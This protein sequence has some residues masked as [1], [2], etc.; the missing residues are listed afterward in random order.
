[1]SLS[2]N[3][4]APTLTL[5]QLYEAQQQYFDAFMI[6]RKL[7]ETNQNDEILSRLDRSK[8]KIFTDTNVI[9]HDLINKIFSFQDREMFRIL[10]QKNYDN[11]LV[12]SEPVEEP[13][14]EDVEFEEDEYDMSEAEDL[15]QI[16]SPSNLP[17][18]DEFQSEMEKQKEY[19]SNNFDFTDN[20]LSKNVLMV[21]EL[22]DFI[23]RQLGKD[24]SISDLTFSELIL[25]YELIKGQIR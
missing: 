2:G 8:T 15:E 12:D 17:D 23:V 6:Y 18:F 16:Y 7:Y 24:K 5:A 22:S 25:I 4:I 1:M 21:S 19:I 13:I 11:L 3:K 20:P 14:F 9:Y 10:P